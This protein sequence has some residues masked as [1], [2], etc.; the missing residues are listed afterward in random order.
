MKVQD[1]AGSSHTVTQLQI[2]KWMDLTAP[3][4]TKI[5]LDMVY[6]TRD[7]VTHTPGVSD[8]ILYGRGIIEGK[9][10]NKV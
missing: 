5:L 10:L 8:Y 9:K 6:K 3:D 4:D 7:L 1:T 2:T